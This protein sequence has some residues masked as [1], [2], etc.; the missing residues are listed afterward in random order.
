M[1]SFTTSIWSTLEQAIAEDIGSGDVTTNALIPPDLK[2]TAVIMAKSDGVIAGLEVALNV[3]ELVDP[4]LESIVLVP[5]GSKVTPGELVGQVS[6]STASILKAERVAL[7]F[8][9]RL[10]GIAT[11]TSLYVQ[12]VAGTEARIIDTRKTIPG[13]RELEKYA[14]R[15]GG[16]FNHR[17]NLSDGILIKDNHIL[18]L[19]EA[20]FTISA[21]IKLARDRSPHTLKVEIE[22]ET[23]EE[24]KEAVEGG[25]DVILLDNMPSSVMK[26]VVDFV[27]GRC[28]LEASGGVSLDTVADIAKTGVN[29]ISVGALTHSA[30]AMDISLDIC[31]TR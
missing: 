20:G 23:I 27:N 7:N 14:I 25:A 12:A 19:R 11:M 9:Q 5:D 2:T 29:L 22:V 28:V 6:G 1:L 13:L 8:L 24:A 15:V 3:F 17:F 4:S 31:N 18:A 30:K 26:E 16:G 10:S 21:I